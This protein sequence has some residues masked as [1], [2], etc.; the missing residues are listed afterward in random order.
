MHI[1]QPQWSAPAFVKAGTFA[2]QADSSLHAKI[3]PNEF[4]N[5]LKT[6]LQLPNLAIVIE[7]IHSN[8]CIHTD[9]SDLRTGDASITQMSNKPLAILTADCLP[10]IVTHQK[11][12]EIANIHAGWRGLYQGI[13]ENT[14]Q[15]LKDNPRQYQVWI[16]PAICQNCYEVGHEFKDNFLQKYP[17]LQNAFSKYQDWH[18]NLA[19]AAEYILKNLGVTQ[20]F[21]S[22]ICTFENEKLFSYRREKNKASRLATLIWLEE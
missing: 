11:N 17:N 12:R 19:Q 13:I 15:Q 7:Q 4:L 9:N 18:F 22:N 14:F 5:H 2:H 10:I 8:I 3:Y 16:G 20:I 6:S 1:I 21:Q